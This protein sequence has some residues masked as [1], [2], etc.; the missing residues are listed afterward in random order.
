VSNRSGAIAPS[1]EQIEISFGEQRAAIVEVG[2]GLRAYADGELQLLD[3]YGADEM[4]AS[5]RGQV[6]VPWPNR[7]RD[8]TYAFGGRTHRLPLTE[9]SRGNAIHGLVRWS[10]WEVR[11]RTPHRVV[12]GHVLHPSPGYPFTLRLEIEYTLSSEGL[13][14]ATT[15]ANAGTEPCPY[16]AGAHPYLTVGTAT[17]DPVVVRVPAHTV[18]ETD[19]QGIPTGSSPVAGTDRDLLRPRPLGA[20]VLDHA[21]TDLERDA[22]GLARVTLTAPDT[23]RTATL[24]V[25]ESYPYLMVFTGDPLPDVARRSLAVEPM[26]CPPDA[27]NSG[28]RLIVLEPGASTTGAWGISGGD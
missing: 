15:A 8:G 16:G 23:G 19:E 12:M 14:V 7:V 18:L 1:G 13:R 5:G 26:T 11:E 22:D 21:F 6:L 9:P 10:R 20:T 24:W 27:F 17:V 3:G 2:G 4:C 25:D 28:E